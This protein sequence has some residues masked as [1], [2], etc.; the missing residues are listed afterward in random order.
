[1]FDSNGVHRLHE[2]MQRIAKL[3]HG[4]A[5]KGDW[6]PFTHHQGDFS[7]LFRKGSQSHFFC[8]ARRGPAT[9]F[10]LL[11]NV[12][13]LAG[14]KGASPLFLPEVPKKTVPVPFCRTAG[15]AIGTFHDY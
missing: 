7:N 13:L 6:H 15:S 12:L 5:G 8:G 2:E 1:M 10:E 4:R 14:K 9:F 3:R 11:T